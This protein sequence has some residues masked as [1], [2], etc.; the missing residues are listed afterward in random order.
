M[1]KLTMLLS[2]LCLTAAL[3]VPARA[4]EYDIAAPGDPE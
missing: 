2:L 1:E 3:A 4:L